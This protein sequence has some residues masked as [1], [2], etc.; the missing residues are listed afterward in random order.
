MEIEPLNN[1]MGAEVRSLDLNQ[2]LD[3]KTTDQLYQAFLDHLLLCI[4]GQNFDFL[5]QFAMTIRVY[6]VQI[7]KSAARIGGKRRIV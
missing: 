3:K 1:V 5:S 4:R 6:L 7:A 2:P